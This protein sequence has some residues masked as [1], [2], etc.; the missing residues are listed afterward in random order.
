VNS[1]PLN[2]VLADDNAA[3]RFFFDKI[4]KELPIETVLTIFEDGSHL[5]NYLTSNPD[6]PPDIIFLDINMPHKTGVEC[7][8]EIHKNNKLKNIH[9]VMLTSSFTRGSYYEQSLI[10]ILKKT[11]SY[12]FIRKDNAEDMKP[13]IHEVVIKAQEKMLFNIQGKL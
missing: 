11:G 7:L 13:F 9:V 5:M 1:I 12:D 4:I 8:S 6:C 3:D 2:I 10:D